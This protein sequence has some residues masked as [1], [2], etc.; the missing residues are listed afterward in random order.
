MQLDFK[1]LLVNAVIFK[2]EIKAK[3][4]FELKQTMKDYFNL[5]SLPFYFKKNKK[6]LKNKNQ[7][8]YKMN[9]IK[10]INKKI[11][12]ILISQIKKAKKNQ[13]QDKILFPSKIKYSNLLK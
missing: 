9:K 4:M 3:K 1:E 13:I 2:Q 12:L 8:K 11:I 7:N 5:K 6:K 10:S